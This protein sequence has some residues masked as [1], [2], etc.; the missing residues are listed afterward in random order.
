MAEWWINNSGQNMLAGVED[1]ESNPPRLPHDFI[2]DF[3]RRIPEARDSFNRLFGQMTEDEQGRLAAIAQAAE[4][5][6]TDPT[7]VEDGFQS[8][9]NKA[10]IQ[11]AGPRG[12]TRAGGN[13]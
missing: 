6:V 9:L 11:T 2:I 5:M 3:L 12:G 7:A 13:Q 8:A 10:G 1:D 4:F